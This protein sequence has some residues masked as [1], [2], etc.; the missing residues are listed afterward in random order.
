MVYTIAY[1]SLL[2]ITTVLGDLWDKRCLDAMNAM[3]RKIYH[4]TSTVASAHFAMNAPLP[5][6][7]N[8]HTRSTPD[9]IDVI[10]LRDPEIPYRRV[11]PT[12][13]TLS[14]AGLDV[15]LLVPKSPLLGQMLGFDLILLEANASTTEVDIIRRLQRIRLVSR[16]PLLILTD[17]ASVQWRIQAIRSGADAILPLDTASSIVLAQCSAMWRRWRSARKE[18]R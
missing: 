13:E 8:T 17:T 14:S 7:P 4:R 16:A 11:R 5:S 12:V 15:W 1:T 2:Q 3:N 18:D 6:A 10:W 9:Q